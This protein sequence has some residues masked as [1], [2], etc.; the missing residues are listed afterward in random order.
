[1]LPSTSSPCVKKLFRTII[2]LMTLYGV[3]N[4]V[5][6]IIGRCMPEHHVL[7]MEVTICQHS[8]D[9]FCLVDF[10]SNFSHSYLQIEMEE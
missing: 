10:I 6:D 7:N 9:I 5:V 3:E 2:A 1:M 8:S 4:Q